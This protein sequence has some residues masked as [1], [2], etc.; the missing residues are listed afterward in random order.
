MTTLAGVLPEL[1]TAYRSLETFG[2]AHGITFA[3][4]DFGGVRTQADTTRILAYRNDDFAAAVRAGTIPA[5][6]SLQR[7]R[8]IAAY[9]SSYHNYGAAFDIRI[10]SRPTNMSEYAALKQL[11]S[12]APTAGLRWG[13]NFSNPDTPHFELAISLDEAKH[14]YATMTGTVADGGGFNIAQYV[15]FLTPTDEESDDG[16]AVSL[17]DDYGSLTPGPDGFI[18]LG[19]LVLGAVAWAVL[20]RKQ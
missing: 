5:D 19:V 18:I 20:S 7:F 11:G 8:P 6:T 9:G 2:A 1:Q 13:G 14:R 17:L 15:P 12:F 10:T 4:A 16:P 3:V